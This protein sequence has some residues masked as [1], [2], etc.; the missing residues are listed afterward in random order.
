MGFSESRHGCKK[1]PD[2]QGNQGVF[3]SCLRERLSRLCSS[4]SSYKESINSRVSPSLP[5]SPADQNPWP[6]S[7]FRAT[8]N[9]FKKSKSLAFVAR[10]F[11][12]EFNNGKKKEKK[13]FWSKLV[14]FKRRKDFL[15]HS[16]SMRFI[17]GRAN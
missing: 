5:F 15:T 3:P 7:S 8:S 13:G 1:H 11:D 6:S 17:I 2:H 12:G 9:G 4:S 10:D 16:S 14:G